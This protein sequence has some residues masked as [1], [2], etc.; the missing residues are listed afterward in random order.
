MQ[1]GVASDPTLSRTKS[2]RR[3]ACG[4][5]KA[6]LFQETARGNEGMA[7]FLVRCRG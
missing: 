1:H 7:L 2:V 4:H 6:V 5:G 3:A